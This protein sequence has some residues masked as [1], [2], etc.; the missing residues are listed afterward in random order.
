MHVQEINFKPKY[1]LAREVPSRLQHS[2]VGK[3]ARLT[4]FRSI[5]NE[6][7]HVDLKTKTWSFELLR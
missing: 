1:Y 4:K 3:Q 7:L 5:N 2:Y 6:Y